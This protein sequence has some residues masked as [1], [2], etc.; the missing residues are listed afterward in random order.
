MPFDSS[1][2]ADFLDQRLITNFLAPDKPPGPGSSK[3]SRR[4]VARKR[5]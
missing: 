2:Q 1:W 4:S 3:S 5:W